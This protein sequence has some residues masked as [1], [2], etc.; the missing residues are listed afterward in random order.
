ITAYPQNSVP[1]KSVAA[2]STQPERWDLDKY[3]WSHTRY[4]NSNK[5]KPVIDF[6]A[7]DNWE[8]LGSDYDLAISPDGNYFAYG[9]QNVVSNERDSLVVQSITGSWRRSFSGKEIKAGFFSIDSKQYIFQRCDE[10]YFL[11][12]GSSE[13][14]RVKDVLSYSVTPKSGVNGIYKWMAY[15]LK[16]KDVVLEDL[17]TGKEKKIENVSSYS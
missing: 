7:L 14:K 15:Q 16:N 10:L 3:V 11:Q 4:K 17:T 2:G 12:S 8:T 6:D 9:I 1:A 5:D 13:C